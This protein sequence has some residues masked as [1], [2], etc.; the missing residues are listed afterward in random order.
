ME[1]KKLAV[2]IDADNT[3]SNYAEVL[4]QEIAKYGRASVRRI[5]GDWTQNPQSWQDKLLKYSLTPIQQFAYTKGKDAT[6]MQ[7][8]IDSMDLLYSK[9][10][11]GFCLV[12]SDSDFT[13]L[14]Q[15]LRQSGMMVYGFGKKQTPE[16]LIMACDNFIYFENLLSDEQIDN[17]KNNNKNQK[18]EQNNTQQ[19]LNEKTPI[20]QNNIQQSL[21]EKTPIEQTIYSAIKQCADE[22]GWSSVSNVSQYIRNVKP[23]YDPRSFNFSQ[24]SKHLKSLGNIQMYLDDKNI[25][26]CRKIPF[27]EFVTVLKE[28]VEKY[29][30]QNGYVDMSKVEYQVKT[31]WNWEVYGFKSFQE[32]L[33]RTHGVTI[34]E[35]K[36]FKYT[37]TNPNDKK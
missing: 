23:D 7:L 35:N 29:Q 27:R 33:E 26:Y 5:Y 18:I 11:D 16:S 25:M 19:S 14:A 20:E 34:S 28:T 3:S 36:K 12:S 2:L 10:F 22:S 13:P 4:F 32:I 24:L 17:D 31:K 21:N 9:T 1:N 6:D 37:V 15:R 30:D 8:I